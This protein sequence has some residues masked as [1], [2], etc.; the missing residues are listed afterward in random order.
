[1]ISIMT[2]KMHNGIKYLTNS[3]YRF[4]WNAYH[5]KY[6]SM[7]DEEYLKRKFKMKVGY[8]LNLSN[9][10]SFNEKIQW[11][12][13][14]D[15]NPQ[16]AKLVDKYEAKKIVSKKW[17]EKYIIPTIGVWN[18]FN[19]ID[20]QKLP[21]EFV[22]KCTHDSGGVV[23]CYDKEKLDFNSAK[24]KIEKCLKHNYYF[25]GRE[26]PYKDIKPRIIAEKLMVSDN[27]NRDL[28]DYKLMCFNGK[29]RC[30]F[31]CSNRFGDG[32]LYVN[33]YDEDWK[34]MP[35]IRKYPK[36]PKEILKP[37]CYDDMVRLAEEISKE[38][39]F[40]RVDFYECQGAIYF[41]E[42][43]FYPGSGMEWFDPVEWDYKLGNMIILP[44]VYN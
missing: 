35:F 1:M 14:H 16:Y 42:F 29:V 22:L 28:N 10:R 25:S 27:E 18:N 36:N 7:S 13:I 15:R 30:S 6:N 11:L 41:G 39:P 23:I 3:K 8:E 26:Y 4:D 31:V 33:F 40:L 37:H 34:P 20:F 2:K 24:I 9:P 44:E 43:T 19:E 21:N 5:G 12:K 32:S 38:I 17:G